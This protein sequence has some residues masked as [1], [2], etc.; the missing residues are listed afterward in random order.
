MRLRSGEERLDQALVSRGLAP[1]RAR[2]QGLI[3]VGAVMVNGAPAAKAS[4]RVG[5]ATGLALT[6][7]PFP[8]VSRAAI[9]LLHALDT[10]AISPEDVVVLDLGASTGGFT[11]VLLERGGREVWAVDVGHGQLSPALRADPRVR[12]IEGVNARDLTPEHV[13]SPGLITADLS[14]IS[15]EKALPPAL[16]LSAPTAFLIALVKPQF[17]VG[18]EHVGKNGIVRDQDATARARADVRTFI[19]RSGWAVLGEAESPILGG[20]G[21]RE[22]LIAAQRRPV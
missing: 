2:A 4:L 18:P 11:Q 8:Y 5:P 3:A 22:Y 6:A 9:K 17:E 10:F 12:V 1:T 14:F 13:P 21:N 19:E 20:D 16:A 7:D 15:L